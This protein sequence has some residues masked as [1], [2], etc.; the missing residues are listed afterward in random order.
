MAFLLAADE[1]LARP[2]CVRESI[3]WSGDRHARNIV[4]RV[5]EE[6]PAGDEGAVEAAAAVVEA[7]E[8]V[9]GSGRAAQD[10][11]MTS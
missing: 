5:L 6:H 4:G 9:D 1:K 10:L 2:G 11:P 7:T 8:E 3:D